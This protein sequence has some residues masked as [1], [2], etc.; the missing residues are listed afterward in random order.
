YTFQPIPIPA[1]IT[2]IG[3]QP[4]FAPAQAT[5]RVVLPRPSERSDDVLDVGVLTTSQLPRSLHVAVY[6]GSNQ[7]I[8]HG[9]LGECR[10]GG[11]CQAECGSA[12]CPTPAQSQLA[13]ELTYD[14]AR[15]QDGFVVITDPTTGYVVHVPV[16][17]TDRPAPTE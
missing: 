15:T 6:D 5:F 2:S 10:A 11:A 17:L 7:E 16:V 12:N 8:A 4:A 1:S 14:V 3:G 13:L 9:F